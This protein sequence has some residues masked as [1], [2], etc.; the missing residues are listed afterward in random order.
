MKK[1]KIAVVTGSRADYGHMFHFLK[2]VQGD[3][4][5]Q[6]QLLVTGMHLLKDCGNTGALI[7][8]DGFTIADKVPI[9]RGRTA[10]MDTAASV[11]QGCTALARS[12]QRLR[13]DLVVLFGDRFETLAACIAAYILRI[14]IAHVHGGELSQ[15]AMDE[16]FRHAITKMAHLHFAATDI[17]RRRII[18]MGEEPRRVF[19]F[20]APGQDLMRHTVLLDKEALAR[21]LGMDLSGPTALV[22]YHPV[23]LAADAGLSHVRHLLAAV[24][25]LGLQAVFTMAN[26]DH[27]GAAINREI[28]MFCRSDARRCRF[29]ESLGT[30]RYLSCLKHLDVVVGNSSSGIVEAPSFGTPAVNIGDRQKGRVMAASVIPSGWTQ[31]AVER[32]LRKALSPAFRRKA[33]AVK[34]PYARF[35]DGKISQRIKDKLKT[36]PLQGLIQKEFYDIQF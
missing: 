17:Y 9:I 3:A 12:F 15:G 29:F 19:N 7:A 18:Q 22:T 1:R 28:K 24:R 4:G 36:V 16:G 27:G 25:A 30:V 35:R 11:G 8:R 32:A 6:L 23:T 31:T 2:A 14:P 10:D 13:P 20:G 34:N 21:E 33:R 26:A 5:L